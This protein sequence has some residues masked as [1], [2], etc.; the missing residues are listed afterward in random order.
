M[1]P[2]MKPN[3]KPYENPMNP[4]FVGDFLWNFFLLWLP[5][6]H[7]QK[8]PLIFSDKAKKE[9]QWFLYFMLVRYR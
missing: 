2:N 6:F 7:V 8:L 9:E 5:L 1:K 4:L 3:M